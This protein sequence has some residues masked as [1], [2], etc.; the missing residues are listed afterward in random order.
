MDV[1]VPCVVV[2]DLFVISVAGL[3]DGCLVVVILAMVPEVVVF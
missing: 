2:I 1:A 3:V